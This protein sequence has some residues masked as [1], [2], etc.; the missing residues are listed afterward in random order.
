MDAQGNCQFNIGS[1]A[2]TRDKD[3]VIVILCFG[4]DL[5]HIGAQ[6]LRADDGKMNT[7]Q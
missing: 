3:Q 2:G 1:S 4:K 7:W 6:H 5:M